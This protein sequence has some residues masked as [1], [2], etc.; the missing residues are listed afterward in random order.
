MKTGY[1]S[2]FEAGVRYERDYL[3][4]FVAHHQEANVSVTLEDLILEI[5]ARMKSEI[6]LEL[7][8]IKN[9]KDTDNE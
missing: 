3:L 4:G 5:R 8:K 1:T 7:T 9:R 2:G 6:E